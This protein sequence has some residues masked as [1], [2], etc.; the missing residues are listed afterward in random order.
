MGEVMKALTLHQPWASL[1]A[2]GVK[3][4][5]TRSWAPP[6]AFI[7][8]RVAI[9]AGRRIIRSGLSRCVWNRACQLYGPGWW[10]EIPAGAVVCTAALADARRVLAFD[11]KHGE[12]VQV[13]SSLAGI[14]GMSSVVTDSFGDFEVGR[15]LWFLEDVRPLNPPLSAVGH[16]GWWDWEP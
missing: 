15:W 2:H 6:R 4:I 11:D 8:Q 14:D 7:G 9:H 10:N 5:E 3:S 12:S 16:Q 1:I 13:S